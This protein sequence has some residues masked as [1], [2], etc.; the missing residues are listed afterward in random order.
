MHKKTKLILGLSLF[1]DVVIIIVLLNWI[2]PVW[3]QDLKLQ[4]TPYWSLGTISN[5]PLLPGSD[6]DLQ[7]T[8]YKD[9][10]T[11]PR[12]TLDNLFGGGPPKDGIPSIDNP[13]FESIN[14]TKFSD[15]ELI[16]GLEI[17]G[18]ARAYPYAILNWHEIVNDTVGDT[19]V[20]VTYCPLCETNTVFKRELDGEVVEFGVSGKLY[21]SC[22]VMY[23]RKTDTLY[24]QPQGIGIV[25]EKTNHVLERIPAI[26]TTVGAWR[27]KYPDAQI[28]TT[29]T[30]HS[31]DYTRYPYGSYYTSDDLIFPTSRQDQRT[32][33]VKEITQIVFTHDTQTPVDR[34]SG[35]HVA[36]T[37]KEI[38]ESNSVEFSWG[39]SIAT[40]SWDKQLE[41][42]IFTDDA[43]KVIPDM[44]L[45][46]FVLPAH[47]K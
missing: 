24:N 46:N 9:S 17:N 42:I 31:R 18:D 39:D 29:E 12:I 27:E 32:E 22:L 4:S 6:A 43:G 33:R 7:D 47:F 44:A 30:G 16:I 3:W 13:V 11:A 19:P 36:F 34:F 23:D 37:Q 26:R 35:N 40:A 14:D 45:F 28:L 10:E 41:T 1:A 21:E 20:S 5:N 8:D 38:R 2:N 25:G 15:D